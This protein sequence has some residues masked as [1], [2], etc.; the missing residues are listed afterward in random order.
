MA[1]CS[2][3]AAECD[4]LR[5]ALNACRAAPCEVPPEVRDRVQRALKAALEGPLSLD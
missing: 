4:G 1:S 5:A 2:P 3:C